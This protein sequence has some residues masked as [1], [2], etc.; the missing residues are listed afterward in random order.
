MIVVQRKAGQARIAFMEWVMQLD[1]DFHMM[2]VL[3]LFHLYSLYQTLQPQV[4]RQHSS[5]YV[6]MFV[7]HCAN[8]MLLFFFNL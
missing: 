6:Q 5:S 7:T 4:V 1:S 2:Y 3:L 8:C